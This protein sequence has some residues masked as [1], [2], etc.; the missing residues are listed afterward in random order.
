MGEK[1]T[2]SFPN[3]CVDWPYAKETRQGYGMIRHGGLY[4]KAYRVMY[5]LFVGAIPP[6]A[7]VL[8]SCDNPSCVNP[9]H[10][11]IGTHAENM[12]DMKSRNRHAYGRR[13]PTAKLTDEIVRDL[14]SGRKTVQA[15]STETGISLTT[16]YQAK[17]GE[18]W[19][20]V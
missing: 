9:A 5:E 8:H 7:S 13:M 17:R 14:R 11:R 10:L 3:G 12:A 19:T 2:Q 15:V 1:E 16:L 6:G 20:H 4:L 18:T